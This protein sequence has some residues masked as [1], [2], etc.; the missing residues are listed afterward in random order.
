[1]ATL[2]ALVAFNAREL[3]EIGRQNLAFDVTQSSN[4]PE[5]LA[6]EWIEQHTPRNAVVL[7][8]QMDVVYHYADR[9]VVWF[10][11]ITDPRVLYEG[12]RKDHVSFVVVFD[13][14]SDTYWRP[15]EK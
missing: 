2:V 10:P 15:A 4:Y 6:A 8:R 1:V 14:G 13:R 3:V 5:I 12:I 11:P 7:A 9:K